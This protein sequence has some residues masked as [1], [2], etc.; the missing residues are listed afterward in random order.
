[1]V[2]GERVAGKSKDDG[3]GY[4]DYYDD[5]ISA[6]HTVREGRRPR[7]AS[8]TPTPSDRRG[9]VKVRVTPLLPG[10]VQ[11]CAGWRR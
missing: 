2:D 8:R 11:M 1:M 7:P 10:S 4:D 6:L 9:A 3:G 5:D